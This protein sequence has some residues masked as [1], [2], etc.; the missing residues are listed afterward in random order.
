MKDENEV[1]NIIGFVGRVLIALAV[2][3]Y[4]VC[5]W[6]WSNLWHGRKGNHA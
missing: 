2:N 4:L 3:S 6:I 5:R 1:G